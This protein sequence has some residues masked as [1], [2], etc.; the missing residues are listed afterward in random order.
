MIIGR[1]RAATDP[2][3]RRSASRN[4]NFHRP[5][6]RPLITLDNDC[7]TGINY[8]RSLLDFSARRTVPELG[9][10]KTTTPSL[11]LSPLSLSLSRYREH[12][13][14]SSLPL[15]ASS[16]TFA[17]NFSLSL[18]FFFSSSSFFLI[19]RSPLLVRLAGDK[20]VPY[21]VAISLYLLDIFRRAAD[22][23]R[24]LCGARLDRIAP[25]GISAEENPSPAS[26]HASRPRA[27]SAIRSRK[28]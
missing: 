15:N 20:Y 16:H 26:A 22:P 5:I 24:R 12:L 28:K 6:S 25:R 2:P 23:R 19:F 7:V 13:D 11:P 4:F 14:I 21:S 10:P 3:M 9:P 17:R 27:E 8:G 1:R 18:F